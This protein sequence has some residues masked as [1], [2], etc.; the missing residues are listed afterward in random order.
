M[1]PDPTPPTATPP[2]PPAAPPPDQAPEAKVKGNPKPG[3]M[4]TY[5]AIV[6]GPSHLDQT[7]KVKKFDAKAQTCDLVVYSPTGVETE[8]V[9]VPPLSPSQP[10]NCWHRPAAK[11]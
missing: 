5:R 9:A 10:Y 8:L 3:D 11:G 2:T 6:N 7:A 4:V 1:P